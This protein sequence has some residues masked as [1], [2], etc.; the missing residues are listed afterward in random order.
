MCS[1]RRSL[2]LAIDNVFAELHRKIDRIVES[3]G[4][5]GVEYRCIASRFSPEPFACI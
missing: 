5:H 4:T 3:A 1:E 2:N